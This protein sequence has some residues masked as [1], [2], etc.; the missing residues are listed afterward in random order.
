MNK[1]ISDAL[2]ACAA[3]V[4]ACHDLHVNKQRA[5]ELHFE[6]KNII[7]LLYERDDYSMPLEILAGELGVLYED[8]YHLPSVPDKAKVYEILKQGEEIMKQF[9][10]YADSL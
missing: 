2:T 9:R 8:V 5:R 6:L 1:I 3:E 10:E 7:D 4:L